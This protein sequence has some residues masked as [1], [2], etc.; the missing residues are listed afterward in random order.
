MKTVLVTLLIVIL[1]MTIYFF[2][3]GQL[4]Q[5]HKVTALNQAR[6]SACPDKPNCLCSEYKDDAAH[7]I[8]PIA[9]NTDNAG[10]HF[11]I[12]KQSVIDMGGDIQHASDNYLSAT[13]TSSIF[14]FVDDLEARLDI[15]NN[16]IHIRSA[17]RVGHSDL[18]ANKKRIETLKSIYQK[19]L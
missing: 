7:Y 18:G 11:A 10:K 17:S 16:L 14:R 19:N 15:E 12:L 3:L 6:L 13:F 4:S 1:L 2:V 9:L 8:N 5:S